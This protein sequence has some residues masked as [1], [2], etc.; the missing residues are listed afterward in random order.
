MQQ[1]DM[2]LEILKIVNSL[3]NDIQQCREDI[4][5]NREEIIKSREENERR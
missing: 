4:K 3:K 2:I 5:Q 1:E